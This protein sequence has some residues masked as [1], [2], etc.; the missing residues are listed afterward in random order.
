MEGNGGEVVALEKNADMLI[1]DH[2]K[3]GGVSPPPGSYSWQWIECSVKN[4]FLQ[5]KSDY[6]IGRA[7]DTSRQIG[8]SE[9]A[10]STRTPFT[11]T[12]DL[13]LTKWV[14]ASLRAGNSTSG[15]E[16]YKEL[17]RR[18][19]TISGPRRSSE[20]VAMSINISQHPHHTW[21]SWR[22]R[23]VKKLSHRPPPNIPAEQL[24]LEADGDPAPVKTAI[25]ASPPAR[26]TRST[27]QAQPSKPIGPEPS[28]STPQ[29]HAP[30]SPAASS[31]SRPAGRARNLFNDEE[32]NMLLE[33]IRESRAANQPLSGN[34]IYQEFAVKVGFILVASAHGVLHSTDVKAQH[35]NHTWHSWRDRW[36]RHLS[37]REPVDDN[38]PDDASNAA[39]DEIEDDHDPD[40]Q[41]PDT[42]Q[43]LLNRRLV[44]AS[45][46]AVRKL[47]VL[48]EGNTLPSMERAASPTPGPS[49][50]AAR[51]NPKSDEERLKRQ[52]QGR[53][54]SRAVEMFYP[55]RGHVVIKDQA[56]LEAALVNL[57]S[58]MRGY[59]VRMK[60]AERLNEAKRA[61]H[62]SVEHLKQ[63][64]F[65]EG[66]FQDADVDSEG[67]SHHDRTA[68]EQFH[69]DLQDYVDAGGEVEGRPSVDGRPIDLWQLFEAAT[70]QDCEPAERN[71][72]QV[73]EELGLDYARIPSLVQSVRQ[74]YQQNLADFE[75]TIKAYDNGDDIE[76]S[77]ED[78][79]N[80]IADGGR[81]GGDLPTSGAV[82]APEQP[83][84]GP[85]SHAYQSSP[86][87]GSKRSRWQSEVLVSDLGY[88]SDGSRKRRR[89]DRDSVIPPT[90]EDKL[91][92]VHG[93]T[94]RGTG[95]E[96]SSPLKS[97]GIAKSEAIELSSG[98][99]SDVLVD[100]E[101]DDSECENE[102]PSHRDPPRKKFVEPETQDWRFGADNEQGFLDSIEEEDASPSQQLQLESDAY[103]SPERVTPSRR[104]IPVKQSADRPSPGTGT[105]STKKAGGIG[106]R[107]LR[108][109][110][111]S[112]ENEASGLHSAQTPVNDKPTKRALP[113]QY[114]RPSVSIPPTPAPALVY[115]GTTKSQERPRQHN[116]IAGRQAR[117]TTPQSTDGSAS[118]GATNSSRGSNS[119]N[120]LVFDADYIEAQQNH[121]QALGYREMD[122]YRALEAATFDR[123]CMTV[124]LESL[125]HGHGIPA[126]EPGVWTKRDNDDLS[127][128]MEH[129]RQVKKGKHAAGTGLHTQ[130]R[131]KAWQAGNRLESKHGKERVKGRTE[132]MM[133]MA[134][135]DE[136]AGAQGG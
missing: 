19:R 5:D 74:C 136:K 32:D 69:N 83:L 44:N 84:A 123:G 25:A 35:P 132:F 76:S 40:T 102:L 111:M 112:A 128:I 29:R 31:R 66:G 54:W 118:H 8:S 126:S 4:G 42:Q 63:H 134:D 96:Y 49:A 30:Q 87:A 71:W 68:R 13:I 23:W 34:K 116:T 3:K 22:D 103:N 62:K 15:N 21:Q 50:A 36:L 24:Q 11:Q 67:I 53:K 39:H 89:L 1:A 20:V 119:P 129:E 16:I 18:V 122:I 115:V 55:G 117:S 60:E 135:A 127:M 130:T 114:Q 48:N 113:P 64:D 7:Q 95:P 104:R 133:M 37:L 131:V 121:F 106:M 56:M 73:T 61:G 80:E 78:E 108:S 92:V 82:T 100:R 125:H 51:I 93:Q 97:R 91:D 86:L 46:P 101:V 47:A 28:R 75:E 107:V 57:Q 38:G 58:R 14:L 88:P 41:Q 81:A 94:S 9:H 72:E 43:P 98:R 99:E 27:R 10:R 12:D 59:L 85:P 45:V 90:P 70:K 52:E 124:A 77:A 120:E 17:E 26:T 65:V 105:A 6:L 79:P 110:T 2:I 33:F 109:K